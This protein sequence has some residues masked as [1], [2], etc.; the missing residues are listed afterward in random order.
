M[1]ATGQA[2]ATFPIPAGLRN[3][4]PRLRT[5]LPDTARP[6]A[7]R[8]VTQVA[9]LA[10]SLPD[11]VVTAISRR[12]AAIDALPIAEAMVD[13][14]RA[15][16]EQYHSVGRRRP[17]ADRWIHAMARRIGLLGRPPETLESVGRHL[18]VTRERVRQVMAKHAFLPGCQRPYL[19]QV[20]RAL[21]LLDQLVP[22]ADAE[23]SNALTSEG[24]ASGQCCYES[25]RAAAILTGRAVRVAEH[26]GMLV[27]DRA[28]ARAVLAAARSLSARYGAFHGDRIR[29]ELAPSAGPALA[30][31]LRR[32]LDAAPDVADLT[33]GHYSYLGAGRNRLAGALTEILS[34]HQPARLADLV[35]AVARHY[36]WRD[37]R[38]GMPEPGTVPLSARVVR[39]FCA[40][41][42]RFAVTERDGRTWVSTNRPTRWR[43]ELNGERAM[44]VDVLDQ[45]PGRSLGRGEFT[46]RCLRRGVRYTRLAVHL[47][48]DPLFVSDGEAVSLFGAADRVNG[49]A[50]R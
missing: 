2:V 4:D 49:D 35:G 42:D 34:V 12:V 26:G 14:L 44:M 46:R 22:C 31:R 24:I 19:P 47:A 20:D 27:G 32:Y 45:A 38:D 28:E 43:A 23:L 16:D 21:N 7:T 5:V 25:L 10:D 30:G 39:E 36:E 18:G 15:A 37:L 8:R 6:A 48:F 50:A 1:G 29:L 40:R 3:D 13:L 11:D 33:G 17:C 9:A 41:H